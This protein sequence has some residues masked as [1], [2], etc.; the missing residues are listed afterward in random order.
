MAAMPRARAW[1]GLLWRTMWP[2][3]PLAA[4]SGWG[5]PGG[6]LM[7]GGF[8]A[9]V[10]PPRAWTSPG[11]TS[12]ETCWRARTPAKDFEMFW[13]RRMGLLYM[14]GVWFVVHLKICVT[15]IG[16]PP[17][18]YRVSANVGGLVSL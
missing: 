18:V 11:W 5:G 10:L 12:K 16:F 3:S 7:R 13:A 1:A 15:R 14:V 2:S 17:G 6:I 9:P 8:P 4:S